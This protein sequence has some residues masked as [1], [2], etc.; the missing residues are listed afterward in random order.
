MIDFKDNKD[1]LRNKK[2]PP[3]RRCIQ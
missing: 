2:T 3:R 1:F